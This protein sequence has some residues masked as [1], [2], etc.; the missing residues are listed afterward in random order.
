[1]RGEIREDHKKPLISLK[2]GPNERR[3]LLI[4]YVA[5]SFASVYRQKSAVPYASEGVGMLCGQVLARMLHP[6]AEVAGGRH[7]VFAWLL[8]GATGNKCLSETTLSQVSEESSG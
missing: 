8:A 7:R 4:D 2:R 1:M 5:D 6:S 3:T